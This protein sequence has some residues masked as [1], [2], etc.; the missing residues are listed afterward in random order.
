MRSIVIDAASYDW[1]GDM[2]IH[3]P[4]RDTVIY[5]LHVGSYTKSRTS[6]VTH[7]G[8]F[9]GLIE[10]IPYLKGLGI[11]A[12]ELM[13]V[14]DFDDKEVMRVSPAD[15]KPLTNFWGY[16]THSFFA[17]KCAYCVSYEEGSHLRD[18]RDMVK[19]FHRA[20][21]E[22]ILD[23][24]FNHPAREIRMDPPSISKAWTIGFTTIWCPRTNNTIWITPAAVIWIT[25]AAVTRLTVITRS[26]KS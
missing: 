3:R 11:T 1:E 22:V 14:M 25:P 5:E 21:I 16:S 7:P 26:P 24:V 10:K 4:M 18:F 23:V 9:S 8:T 2:P 19:A 13:P 6:G 15:G 20:G 12:V 17:P